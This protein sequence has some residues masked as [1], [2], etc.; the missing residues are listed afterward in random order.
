MVTQTTT[1]T[2]DHTDTGSILGSPHQVVLFNDDMHSFD[3]V[4]IQ[5]CKA[6]SCD[7]GRA[8][9]VANEAHTCGRAV[10]FTGSQERCEH[11]ES[12]LA[13][14]PTRLSTQIEIA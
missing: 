2:M 4:I 13:G 1:I 6:L 14:P 11:V 8:R 9:T 3:E 7:S 5:L 10:A 12:I